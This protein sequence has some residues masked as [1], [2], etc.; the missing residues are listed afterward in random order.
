MRLVGVEPTWALPARLSTWCVFHFRH[1]R[2]VVSD[3]LTMGDKIG[4]T[5]L[6]CSSN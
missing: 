4:E 3:Y 1:G 2:G 5:V 6:R